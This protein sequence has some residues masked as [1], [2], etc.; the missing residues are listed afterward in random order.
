VWF[1]Y[2]TAASQAATQSGL[3]FWDRKT[4]TVQRFAAPCAALVDLSARFPAK[5]GNCGGDWTMTKAPPS[6]ALYDDAYW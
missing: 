2:A 3:W 1:Y 4:D 6:A 5:Y